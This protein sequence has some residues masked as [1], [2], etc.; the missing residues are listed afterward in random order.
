MA[1]KAGFNLDSSV[2]QN[3]RPHAKFYAVPSE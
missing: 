2:G 1:E 3:S